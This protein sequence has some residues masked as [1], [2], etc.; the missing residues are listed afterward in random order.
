MKWLILFLPLIA[1]AGYSTIPEF[2]DFC[3]RENAD[4]CSLPKQSNHVKTIE[5][6]IKVNDDVNGE[7]VAARDDIDG[8]YWNYPRTD[9]AY[10]YG[11]CEDFALEKARRLAKLG[12]TSNDMRL[13]VSDVHA[14]LLVILHG[15][16]YILDNNV[17]DWNLYLDKIQVQGTRLF[18]DL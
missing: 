12:W 16:E 11:D 18:K 13:G 3:K 6:L 4:I 8:D 2:N 17:Y 15:N 14:V 1:N 9:E 7:I 10:P 5:E